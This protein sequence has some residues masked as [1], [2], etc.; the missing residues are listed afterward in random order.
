MSKKEE[1]VKEQVNPN[2]IQINQ[3]NVAQLQLQLSVGIRDELA[4]IRKALE[5]LVAD[6]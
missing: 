3:G 2:V 5:A 6:K 1:P 4:G